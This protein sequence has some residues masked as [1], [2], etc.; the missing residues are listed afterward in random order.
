MSLDRREFLKV[1]SAA[2]GGLVLGV[3]FSGCAGRQ[4]KEMR[5]VAENSG[6]FRPNMYLTITPGDEVFVDVEKSEMGQ[7]VLTSHSMLVAEELEVDVD[8]I[9]ASSADAAPE[10]QT[11]FGQQN[12]GGSTSVSESFVPVRKAAAAAR[13]M[14]IAAAAARW[15]VP[16]D[17]C[18]AKDGEVLHDGSDRSLRYGAL[19]EEAAQVSIPDDPPVKDPEDFE[20]VGSEAE[21]VDATEKVDGSAV[22]GIDVEVDE[23][24][25]AHCIHPPVFGADPEDVDASDARSMRGV[26]DIFPFARGVAVV[27]EKHWQAQRAAK[28]VEVEWSDRPEA[29]LDTDRLE[30][31]AAE[32]ASKSG[33]VSHRSG[34]VD[35]AMRRDDVSVVEAEY[36]SPYLAHAPMEPQN[37]TVEVRDGEVEIWAPTQSQTVVQD[38]VA[39]K[40]GLSRGDIAV[41]TTLLG[42][43]FGRRLSPDFV[44]ET[45]AIAERFDRPVQLLWSREDDMRGGYYRPLNHNALQAAVDSDGTPVAWRYHHVSP[46]LAAHWDPFLASAMPNWVPRTARQVLA[47]S[48]YALNHSGSAPEFFALEGAEPRYAID[49]VQLEITPIRTPVPV[50]HWRSVGNSYNGFVVESFIDELAHHA[51]RD[52]Y[53]FRRELLDD[54]PRMRRV[55]ERA[56]EEGGWE[57]SP[58]DPLGQ[59]IATTVAFGTPVA[60]YVEAGIVDGEIDVERVVC[61]VDCGVVVNPD[62]V[63]AQMEGSIIF[64]LSA[65]LD[66]K[67]SVTEGRVEPGNF[68]DYPSLRMHDTPEIEVHVLR[69]DHEPTGAGEPGVPPAAPALA[70]AIYDASGIRLR[71]MPFRD[72]LRSHLGEEEP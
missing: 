58:A 15:S 8:R 5:H 2:A 39:R 40:M 72:A 28:K 26:V 22:F 21:R 29:E 9:E 37:C 41:H 71:R 10:Y 51:D 3:S 64:A 44:L 24:L 25:C 42:G 70:N 27:A 32:T 52:P 1:S 69:T 66:Q 50:C 60:E 19:T 17:E 56:A 65:A 7:G 36:A 31:V 54:A 43:G 61:V 34:D 14:L 55:L 47:N 62:L 45:V 59:G 35:R 13:E 63:A 67:V 68:D 12:T 6:S 11:S 18:R 57:R 30:E 33:R 48:Y 23:M 16:P 38:A 20:V 49:N 4:R 46:P 53:Q